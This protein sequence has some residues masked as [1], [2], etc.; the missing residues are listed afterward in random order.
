MSSILGDL[1]YVRVYIDDIIIFSSSIDEH[2]EHLTEVLLRLNRNCLRVQPPKY[3]FFRPAVPY[4]GHVVS[5]Q[6]I[7]IDNTRVA[8]IANVP[9]PTAG[10]HMQLFLGMAKSSK[11]CY[12]V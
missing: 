1:P 7:R 2:A 8:E 4:L 6:G 9:R 11:R 10:K 12:L 3:R 5:G